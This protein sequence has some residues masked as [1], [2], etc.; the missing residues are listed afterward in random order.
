VQVFRDTFSR[1]TGDLKAIQTTHM[2]FQIEVYI[3]SF[4]HRLLRQNRI[5]RLITSRA[6][7]D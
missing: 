1:V 3:P 2:D 6:R 7:R 4:I 5:L